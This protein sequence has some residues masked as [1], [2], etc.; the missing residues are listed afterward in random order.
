MRKLHQIN[1]FIETFCFITGEE[2]LRTAFSLV[3]EKTFLVLTAA[4][5]VYKGLTLYPMSGHI[6]GLFLTLEVAYASPN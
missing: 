2:D 5:T 4:P 3:F 1:D 6:S